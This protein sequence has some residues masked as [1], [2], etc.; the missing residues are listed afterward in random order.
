MKL[1]KIT[2]I[3][4][5]LAISGS[6]LAASTDPV[7][8]VT[9]QGRTLVPEIQSLDTQL[10]TVS[11]DYNGAIGT[12]LKNQSDVQAAYNSASATVRTISANIESMK[13]EVAA[14][15]RGILA[16]LAG[17]DNAMAGD[18]KV[19]VEIDAALQRIQS[20]ITRMKADFEA[21]LV[22]LRTARTLA[23]QRLASDRTALGKLPGLNLS[24]DDLAKETARLN[25]LISSELSTIASLNAEQTSR[26]NAF[27]AGPLAAA[28]AQLDRITQD[29]TLVAT[30]LAQ[31]DLQ[32]RLTA[33]KQGSTSPYAQS[34]VRA[35]IL[36]SALELGA[37]QAK[38]AEAKA[39]LDAISANLNDLRA[40]QTEAQAA[41]VAAREDFKKIVAGCQPGA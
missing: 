28:T 41:I 32:K 6:A 4:A 34:L 18:K 5:A 23:E 30:H 1:F 3:A 26:T 13:G 10:A 33:V 16:D 24:K 12:L 29:R 17:I 15:Q 37:A 19:L 40:K 21:S 27:K 25:A 8:T 9:Q 14:A 36:R 11:N 35:P 38:A 22:Q 39:R 20:D 7:C 31:L 2:G